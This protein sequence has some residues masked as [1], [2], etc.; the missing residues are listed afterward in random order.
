MPELGFYGGNR[1]TYPTVSNNIIEKKSFWIY[2]SIAELQ[3]LNENKVNR[4]LENGE[5]YLYFGRSY[6][7]K[8]GK[9]LKTPLSLKQ[10]FFLLDEKCVSKAKTH[11]IDFYKEKGKEHIPLRV[12]YFKKKIGVNP[13]KVRIMELKKRWASKGKT[14]INFHWKVMLAPISVIDYIILH[15]L[16]HIIKEDHSPEFW[17]I[18]ESVMPNYK[19]KKN[20]LRTNGSNMDI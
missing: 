19:E 1:G 12:E 13:E 6:R 11:F 9:N 4:R 3:E 18:V 7:L 20:W 10:G 15:E 14:G 5:G 8:I 16:A 2:K 17:E